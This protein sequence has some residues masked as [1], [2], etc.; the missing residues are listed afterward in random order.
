V[1]AILAILRDRAWRIPNWL[2]RRLPNVD[3]EGQALA[4]A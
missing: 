2:D 3:I 4:E 1:P